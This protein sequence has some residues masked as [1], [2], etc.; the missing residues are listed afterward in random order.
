[1]H[2]VVHVVLFKCFADAED[3]D[4]FTAKLASLK[5]IWDDVTPWFYEWFKKHQSESFKSCLVISSG[6]ELGISGR[7]YNNGLENRHKLQKKESC[8]SGG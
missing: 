8:R 1:M 3:V 6:E 4:D 2:N 5:E 7:Y